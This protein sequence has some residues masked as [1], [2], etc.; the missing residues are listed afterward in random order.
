MARSK[1]RGTALRSNDIA[2]AKGLAA[3]ALAAKFPFNA[4]KKLEHGR[5]NAIAPTAGATAKPGDPA[6]T[7]STLSEENRAGRPVLAGIPLED[8]KDAG[9]LLS[10]PDRAGKIAPAFIAAM[11]AH[12]HA[13]RDS[14][15]P[16]I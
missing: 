2:T 3:D 14:D 7:G 12:R 11:A 6:L 13:S 16:R 10:E 5:A 8:G 9:I 4:N 1:T 15:P